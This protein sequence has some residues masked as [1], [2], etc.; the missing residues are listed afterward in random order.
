MPYST[1]GLY[2]AR[3]LTGE[4]LRAINLLAGTSL[5]IGYVTD[6]TS[7]VLHPFNGA[8]AQVEQV[9][10]ADYTWYVVTIISGTT[11]VTW[12]DPHGQKH[13]FVFNVWPW[14]DRAKIAAR[15]ETYR[16]I[17]R[18]MADT[19]VPY[20]LVKQTIRGAGVADATS[21]IR[22]AIWVEDPSRAER[23]APR[24]LLGIIERGAI[25]YAHKLLRETEFSELSDTQLMNVLLGAIAYARAAVT[26]RKRKKW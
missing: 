15:F 21:A 22:F 3:E 18:I 12:T 17:W 24:F 25:T 20:P 26:S 14:R 23:F 1:P 7:L 5:H 13:N 6:V 10:E 2:K 19:G 16:R 11:L 4:K 9:K 8:R